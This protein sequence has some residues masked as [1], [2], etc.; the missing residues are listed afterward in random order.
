MHE[1]EKMAGHYAIIKEVRG[2]G[3]MLAL[4]FNCDKGFYLDSV[5]TKL[6][7]KGLLVGYKPAANLLR[8]Y[9]ELTITERDI[10][11]SGHVIKQSIPNI[12]FVTSFAMWG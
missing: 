7:E 11:E 12:A 8:F 2:R 3:L 10:S 5:Y 4:E 6:L 1:L 9:P